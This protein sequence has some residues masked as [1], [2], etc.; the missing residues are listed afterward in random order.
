VAVPLRDIVTSN[1]WKPSTPLL[2]A[3]TVCVVCRPPGGPAVGPVR[4]VGAVG[5]E[6]ELPQPVDPAATRTTR[7]LES[8]LFVTARSSIKEA[9]KRSENWHLGY[10]RAAA[11]P[12]LDDGRRVA[13]H[14]GLRGAHQ[15]GPQ[16]DDDLHQ[17]IA[18][19]GCR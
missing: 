18:T 8:V 1:R 19:S 12:L 7:H 17:P 4:G 6:L 14:L 13:R 3:G 10:P 9:E 5:N 2:A 15:L 11:Q 16:P